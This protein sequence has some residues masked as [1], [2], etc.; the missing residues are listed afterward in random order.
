MALQVIG[1]GLGRTGTLSLKTALEQLGFSQCYHMTEIFAHPEHVPVWAAAGRGEPVDWEALFQG[2][3]ATVDWPGCNF[4]RE[5]LERNPEARVILTVRDPE[6]WYDSAKQ[7]I[8][9]VRTAFPSWAR[10]VMPRMGRFFAMVN[11]LI[12]DGFFG[13]R[14]E[15]RAYAIELFQRHNEEVRRNVP[16]DRLLVYEVKEGWRPLCE[17]LGVPIPEGQPFPHVN[18]TEEFRRRTRKMAGV[19][20]AIEVGAGSLVVLLVG[21]VFW[22]AFR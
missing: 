16:A 20:R 10:L 21:L 12:W 18:D 5:F 8:Y 3:R 6:R 14:F 11:A 2:Y 9:E 19:M 13:G 4:Y 7:T 15:D 17:F 1:A 22:L